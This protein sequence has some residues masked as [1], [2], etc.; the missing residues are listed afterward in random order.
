MDRIKRIN[1][2]AGHARF[3]AEV[4]FGIGKIP[5]QCDIPSPYAGGP[6][7]IVHEWRGRKIIIVETGHKKYDV[8]S[9]PESMSLLPLE[10]GEEPIACEQTGEETAAISREYRKNN[11]CFAEYDSKEG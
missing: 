1:S 5:R 4:N 2:Y 10:E 9:V 8:F 6:D 3:L 11:R 7:H